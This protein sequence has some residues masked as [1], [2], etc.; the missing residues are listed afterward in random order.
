LDRRA[1]KEKRGRV[2]VVGGTERVPGAVILASIASLRA[3]AGKLQ[4]GVPASISLYVGTAIP[5]ALVIPLK[6]RRGSIAVAAAREISQYAEGAD[7]IALGPGMAE[8][9]SG[10]FVCDVLKRTR[11]RAVLDAGALSACRLAG[12]LQA[13]AV[14][15]PHA[16][17]MATLLD[18]ERSEVEEH[19]ARFATAAA[20]RFNAVVALKGATTYIAAPDG[21]ILVNEEGHVGLATSGSGDALAGVIAGLLA[22]GVA[23]LM[24][25]AW[26]VYLHAS[27]GRA[28]G[29]RVGIGFLAHEVLAEIPS[30]MKR[31]SAKN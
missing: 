9:Y 24:A 25:A 6:E 18:C 8:N 28:L 23:P 22:R 1:D 17:E 26:G 15:T 14:L 16:G 11:T 29:R 20:Q 3:G 7:A 21:R 5:E 4:I 27:A 10:S 13:R 19:P 31:L 30:I 2:L 12:D